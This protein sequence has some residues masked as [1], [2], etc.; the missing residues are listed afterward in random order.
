MRVTEQVLPAGPLPVPTAGEDRGHEDWAEQTRRVLTRDLLVRAAYAPPGEARALEFR[1]L[2]LNL[3]LVGEVAARLGLGA[4]D[5]LAAEHE[6]LDGLLEAV[7][8]YDPYGEAEFA[9]V[10]VSYL[11]QRLR[12]RPAPPVL[13]RLDARLSSRTSRAAPR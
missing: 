2:H 5:V 10:A 11:E 13:H 6:A 12:R 3:P 1:A 7:R 4:T 8:A 9:E